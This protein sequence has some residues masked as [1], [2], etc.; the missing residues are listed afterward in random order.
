MSHLHE[1]VEDIFD[2]DISATNLDGMKRV[3]DEAS[4][5]NDSLLVAYDINSIDSL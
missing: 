3:A 1:D 5:E 2:D 4:D